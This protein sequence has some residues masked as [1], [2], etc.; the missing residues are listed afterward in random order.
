MNRKEF[1]KN[2]AA[3]GLATPFMSTLF[4]SCDDHS[5]LFPEIE[6]GFNGKVLIIG[7]GA[8]GMTAGYILKRQNIDFEIIEAS[9]VHGGRIKEISGFADFPIDLGGEWIHTNP[10]ILS[11]LLNNRD[12]NADIEI[13]NYN[14]QTIKVWKNNQLLN[15]NFGRHFYSEHKFKNTTWYSFFDQFIIPEIGHKIVYDQPVNNIDYSGDKVKVNSIHGNE[16]EADK[17]IVTVP[18]SILQNNY[19]NFQPALPSEK[20]AAINNIYIPA[21]L[22]V[23]I[24][25]SERFYSDIVFVGGLNSD[26]IFY[27]AAFKKDSSQ[28]IFGLFSVGELAEKYADADSEQEIIDD[29]LQLLDTMFD[30][31]AS[32]TYQKHVIQNWSQEPFIQGSYS[33]FQ[34]SWGA[35]VRTLLEPVNNKVYFA[36]EAL[37]LNGDTATVHGAGESAYI[38]MEELLRS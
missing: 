12:A 22:K 29:L 38:A 10:N 31:K 35:T 4:A 37:N 9:S 2:F 6:G 8:A 30:G 1:L 26:D 36:G 32:E 27:D 23:F 28:N 13:I 33:H 16:Y 7:A 3:L 21:G 14:P 15:R 11:K 18:I 17:V 34:G 20:T 19:I 25:F 5:P 24:E